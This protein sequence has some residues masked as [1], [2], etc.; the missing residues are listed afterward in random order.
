MLEKLQAEV[1]SILKGPVPEDAAGQKKWREHLR[2]ALDAQRKAIDRA[3]R[4]LRAALEKRNAEL[5]PNQ[6][7]EL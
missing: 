4:D 2:K 5:H 6:A 3:E 7:K 1:D